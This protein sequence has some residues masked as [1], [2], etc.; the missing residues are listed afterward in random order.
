M[1]RSA[2][3]AAVAPILL[4]MTGHIVDA[5]PRGAR[6]LSL[7]ELTRIA[8]AGP[9]AQAARL[10]TRQAE[11]LVT[12]AGG[13]RFP[14]IEVR[15]LAAPSPNIDCLNPD[16]T[17]TSHTDVNL[18][19]DGAWGSVQV[20]LAQPLF[21]F[22]KLSA[23]MRGAR[24]A[25]AAARSSESGVTG[26]IEVDAARAYFGLKLAREL[27]YELEDGLDEIDKARRQLAEALSAKKGGGEATVQ[28]RLRLETVLGEARSRLAEARE[29]ED[30]A[31]AAV[32]V[33]AGDPRAD[34]DDKP[35]E[36]DEVELATADHYA[37]LA[38]AVR[39]E[40]AALRH[41]QAGTDA[42]A[43]LELARFFPDFLLVGTFQWARAQGVDDPPSAFASD[44]F[45]T[46]TVGL[47]AALRWTIEPF[48]QRGRLA[49]ARARRDEVSAD[50]RAASGAVRLDVEHAHAQARSAHGRL[51]AAREGEKSARGWV[52]SVLQGEAIG[53]VEAK[54]LAD[55]YLAYFSL[56]ARYLTAVHDWNLALVRLRR[57]TG[58]GA[59]PAPARPGRP[60]RPAPATGPT[61]STIGHGSVR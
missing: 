39:P 21:T 32:R 16:C 54:E 3:F 41:A 4:V 49:R 55:A 13:A 43:D 20:N 8:V 57:A 19:F 17:E 6:R 51:E 50:L 9:R 58:P 29:A 26:D 31:L 40:L 11:A 33:M 53:V 56:R 61:D 12:E 44:P 15:A 1:P 52:A 42:L 48:S 22:G 25:A 59:G 45:N 47:A 10:A 38:M 30:T 2:A 7:A 35:L 36:P 5:Q 27:R 23:A 14:H 28:D 60:N 34:I 24:S 46:T 18:A 37:D